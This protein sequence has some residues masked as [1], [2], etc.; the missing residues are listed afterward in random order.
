MKLDW[1]ISFLSSLN[2]SPL[3]IL[4]FRLWYQGMEEKQ[5]RAAVVLEEDCLGVC[6]V[7]SVW[8][9]AG[10]P[11]QGGD[12]N[13]K[14]LKKMKDATGFLL[15]STD[16]FIY[17]NHKNPPLEWQ[18]SQIIHNLMIPDHVFLSMCLPSWFGDWCSLDKNSYHVCFLL[19]ILCHFQC[20]TLSSHGRGCNL[21]VH[22]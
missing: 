18:L 1:T 3:S 15:T 14:R 20:S 5:R 16:V 9:C 6:G 8:A 4:S 7:G 19:Q 22:G 12:L 13:G 17:S 21:V 10:M 11:G 2:H